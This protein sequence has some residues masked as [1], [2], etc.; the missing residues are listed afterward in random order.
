MY[1]LDENPQ[2]PKSK[3]DVQVYILLAKK[4]TFENGVKAASC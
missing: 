3:T 4:L 2:V 1:M